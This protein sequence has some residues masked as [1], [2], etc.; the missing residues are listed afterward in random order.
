MASAI[1]PDPILGRLHG[2]FDEILQIGCHLDM[3]IWLLV[4]NHWPRELWRGDVS[5]N[6]I[7]QVGN[8]TLLA[9][10]LKLTEARS[11]PYKFSKTMGDQK[12][13]KINFSI[14]NCIS[15]I[16]NIT[17]PIAFHVGRIMSV[18]LPANNA[19]NFPSILFYTD[20][21][22]TSVTNLIC[23]IHVF[24]ISNSTR[25]TVETR[26][27]T[28]TK[29]N[30]NH[31]R[32]IVKEHLSWLDEAGSKLKSTRILLSINPAFYIISKILFIQ[33]LLIYLHYPEWVSEI[34]NV[35]SQVHGLE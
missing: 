22:M 1:K 30:I 27:R 15:I 18:R 7:D 6:Q 3:T 8:V 23:K 14:G 25:P 34:K 10:Q 13:V 5:L 32:L 21:I 35:T 20:H 11:K 33:K 16:Q 2:S 26:S 24:G 31:K 29:F 4:P 12:I 19:G 17:L 28:S 9:M